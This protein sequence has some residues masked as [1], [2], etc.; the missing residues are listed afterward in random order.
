MGN[1]QRRRGESSVRRF[2]SS[3]IEDESVPLSD[4]AVKAFAPVSL[5]LMGA[6]EVPL[7]ASMPTKSLTPTQTDAG[8]SSAPRSNDGDKEMQEQPGPQNF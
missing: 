5:P 2:L 6:N 3:R 8:A 7:A 4:A 1:Y